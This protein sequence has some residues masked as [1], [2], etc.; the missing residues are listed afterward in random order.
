MY[1]S[2]PHGEILERE[3]PDCILPYVPGLYEFISRK[4]GRF[5]LT[6]GYKPVQTLRNALVR[7]RP[8]PAKR[9]GVIYC[10]DCGDSNC[11]WRYIGETGRTM[12]ERVKEHKRYLKNA[13]VSSEIVNHVLDSGHAMNFRSAKLLDQARNYKRRIIKEA[14]WSSKGSGNKVK[15]SVGQS[16]SSLVPDF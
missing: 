5:G 7:K 14:F 4:L 13:D 16:W 2:R 12:E 9:F 15:F 10:I 8:S 1:F 3:P 11:Q 6:T